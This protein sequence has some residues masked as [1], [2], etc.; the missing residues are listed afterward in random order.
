MKPLFSIVI[1][2]Y[3]HGKFLE[4]AILSVLNQSCNDFELIVIDG[5][6]SDNSVELIKKYSNLLS[7]WIS[8]P[9][10]GQSDAFN[11]GFNNAN[12][13]F[14]FWINADDILLPRSLEIAKMNIQLY[15]TKLW[16]TANIIFF[17][18]NG[19][20]LKC[21]RGPKW[22]NFLF[23][24]APINV[25]GPT[26]IFHKS[27]FWAAGG[28]DVNLKFAM[29]TDLWMRFKNMG[30]KFHRINEYFWGFRVHKGSKTSNQFWGI[31]N[32]YQYIEEQAIM[33]KNNITYSKSGIL[34][35]MAYKFFSGLYL[36]SF[37]DS[38]KFKGKNIFDIFC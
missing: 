20:I 38:I 36:F 13:E 11:K 32:K 10:K 27:I 8:E 4:Q 25:Y 7:Y 14:F 35:Q 18:E 15:P 23:N 9:D 21:S 37:I 34:I 5:G 12:G 30:I 22:K 6:S 1:A 19:Q 17:S 29:D 33:N 3:N 16:F 28:F 26:S 31:K 24:N 2:N